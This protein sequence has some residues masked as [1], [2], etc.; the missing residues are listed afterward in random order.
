MVMAFVFSGKGNMFVFEGY[1]KIV[2]YIV[3]DRS[4]LFVCF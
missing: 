1:F 3:I 4:V 2:N